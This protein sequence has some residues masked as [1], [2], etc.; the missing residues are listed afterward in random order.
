MI[1]PTA[2]HSRQPQRPELA[3]CATRHASQRVSDLIRRLL[4]AEVRAVARAIER[5]SRPRIRIERAV[6][7]PKVELVCAPGL[8][9]DRIG[10]G[11][12]DAADRHLQKR[13]RQ[14]CERDRTIGDMKGGRLEPCRH[15][16]GAHRRAA[17]APDKRHP[18]G[19]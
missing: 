4:R 18:D 7:R 10:P 19:S 12:V 6:E 8:G 16:A 9:D 1:D 13:R 5:E 15:R 3:A 2:Y 17:G 14:R 11:R